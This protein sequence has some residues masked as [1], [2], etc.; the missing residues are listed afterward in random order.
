MTGYYD[1]PGLLAID[2]PEEQYAQ[3]KAAYERARPLVTAD[4]A[5][6]LSA[7]G[8]RL[9]SVADAIGVDAGGLSRALSRGAFVT[10]PDALHRLGKLFLSRSCHE[11]MFGTRG[12]TI[13]PGFLGTALDVRRATGG[14]RIFA[15]ALDR[16]AAIYADEQA[17]GALPKPSSAELLRERLGEL[18]GERRAAIPNI[19][20]RSVCRQARVILRNCMAPAGTECSLQSLMYFAVKAGTSLDYFIAQD[21]TETTPVAYFRKNHLIDADNEGALDFVSKFLRLSPAGQR[22]LLAY[23]WR[24]LLG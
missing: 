14:K 22:A 1:I 7:K 16:A 8:Y 24:E 21:Y 23:T 15:G 6:A 18:A 9:T 10:K 3:L 13:L 20:G 19:F 11:I 17:R 4:V 2:D 5:G 12:R